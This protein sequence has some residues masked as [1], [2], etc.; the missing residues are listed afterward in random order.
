VGEKSIITPNSKAVRRIALFEEEEMQGSF[1]EVPEDFWGKKSPYISSRSIRKYS[2]KNQTPNNSTPIPDKLQK[3][4][5]PDFFFEQYKKE[6]K[7]DLDPAIS[8]EYL[9]RLIQECH[10]RGQLLESFPLTSND[11]KSIR[12]NLFNLQVIMRNSK[13]FRG[14]KREFLRSH[15]SVQKFVDSFFE[16][17]SIRQPKPKPKL[18]PRGISEWTKGSTAN[19]GK[20]VYRSDCGRGQG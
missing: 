16:E 17:V 6:Y 7:Q 14:R 5:L 12:A 8:T 20:G 11:L 9:N 10:R 3:L 13:K 4:N 18:K 19:S 2:N 1:A 15:E